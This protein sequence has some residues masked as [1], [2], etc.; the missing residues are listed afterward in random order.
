MLVMW[1]VAPKDSEIEK[2]LV[3]GTDPTEKKRR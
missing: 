2:T 3:K 1:A